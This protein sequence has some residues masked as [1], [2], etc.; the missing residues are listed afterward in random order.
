MR[1]DSKKNPASDL[2]GLL[3]DARRELVKKDAEIVKLSILVSRLQEETSK[4]EKEVASLQ[5]SHSTHAPQK[6]ASS[7][8]REVQ[9][10]KKLLTKVK[11]DRDELLIEKEKGFIY[12]PKNKPQTE[13]KGV[14]AEGA[15]NQVYKPNQNSS[16][17][18]HGF[19]DS[20]FLNESIDFRSPG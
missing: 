11:Q 12:G 17:G 1:F 6:P 9:D 8:E 14:P 13:F 18:K 19:R 20:S 2:E 4:L 7:L 5:H 15:I 10:L 16:S 3:V